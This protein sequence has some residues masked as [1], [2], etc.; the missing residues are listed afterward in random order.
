MQGRSIAFTKIA[1]PPPPSPPLSWRLPAV[2]A[3]WRRGGG[4]V[5]GGDP[6]NVP[7]TRRGKRFTAVANAVAFF[8]M[9]DAFV[10]LQGRYC[11]DNGGGNVL[12]L[13]AC[14][15]Q[16]WTAQRER[17]GGG[18]GCSD[19]AVAMLPHGGWAADDTTRGGGGAERV[20]QGVLEADDS[21]RGGGV[22]VVR[23]AGG[24]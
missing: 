15:S 24:R 3:R 10:C 12:A 5:G 18:G 14:K 20:V 23:Q 16:Q 2:A 7:R 1:F 6:N 4:A 21:V 19:K 8:T 13:M 9:M 17:E 22:D 11:V